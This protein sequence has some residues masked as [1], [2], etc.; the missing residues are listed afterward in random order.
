MQEKIK[1]QK[2]LYSFSENNERTNERSIERA[3][4]LEVLLLGATTK[5]KQNLKCKNS[6]STSFIFQYLHHKQIKSVFNMIH[7]EVWKKK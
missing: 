5:K 3:I 2:M 6:S 1:K 7:R 4:K